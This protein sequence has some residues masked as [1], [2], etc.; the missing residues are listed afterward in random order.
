[1]IS[2]K[3]KKRSLLLNGHKTSV[4]LEEPFWIYFCELASKQNVSC[5]ALASHIDFNRSPE[6]GLATSIRIFCLAEARKKEGTV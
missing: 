2:N 3:P 5:S 1:M 4:S 6:V